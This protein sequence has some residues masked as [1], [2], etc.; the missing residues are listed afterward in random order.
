MGDSKADKYVEM[1]KHEADLHWQRNSYFLVTMS[2]FLLTLSQFKEDWR[3][4]FVVSFL[5]LIISIVWLL[6]NDRSSRYIG[7]WKQ[8]AQKF[9]GEV[10]IYSPKVG[11]IQMRYLAY[12]MPITFTLLWLILLEI[13]YSSAPNMTNMTNITIP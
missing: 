7:Y 3:I 6:I 8:E 11:G 1:Q 4:R 10:D 2:L 5:G 13:S 9:G 12:I